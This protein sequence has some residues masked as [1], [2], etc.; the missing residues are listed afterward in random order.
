[1]TA[2]VLSGIYVYSRVQSLMGSHAPP[3]DGAARYYLAR[4]ESGERAD[5][6]G[7]EP[8]SGRAQRSGWF[9]HFWRPGRHFAQRAK[10]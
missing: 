6:V 1:M 9:E 3:E 8:A 10:Q 4:L 5:D 2:T 7:G